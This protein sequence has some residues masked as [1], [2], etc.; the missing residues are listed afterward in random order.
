M[1]NRNFNIPHHFFFFF[2]FTFLNCIEAKASANNIGV[3]KCDSIS[4]SLHIN[5]LS[6]FKIDY[7]SLSVCISAFQS[8]SFESQSTFTLGLT[9]KY[10]L[11]IQYFGDEL[12]WKFNGKSDLGF[13][14]IVDSLWTKSNDY[15]E[16]YLIGVEKH[17]KQ[18]EMSYSFLL[19]SQ[20]LP[21][22]NYSTSTDNIIKKNQVGG[23]LN[24]LMLQ[25]AYGF[26]YKF[27]GIGRI[28]CSLATLRLNSYKVSGDSNQESAENRSIVTLDYGFSLVLDLKKRLVKQLELSF[29]TNFFANSLD[30]DNIK[31]NSDFNLTYQ[32]TKFIAL[33]F[34]SRFKYDTSFSNKLNYQNEILFSFSYKF[35]D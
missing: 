12:D 22:Y 31:C 19:V 14:Y 5:K 17:N 6:K 33:Q 7:N 30:R 27:H 23:F 24:P 16:M 8:K 34:S 13:V 4:N 29:N 20:V 10:R 26:D 35:N 1:T 9:E 28:T 11:N 3:N 15:L 32:V 2:F 18:I 21:S 25:L